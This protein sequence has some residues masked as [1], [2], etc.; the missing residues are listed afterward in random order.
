MVRG[1][2]MRYAA[3]GR[4]EMRRQELARDTTDNGAASMMTLPGL[5]A[6]ALEEFLGS[7]MRRRFDESHAKTLEIAYRGRSIRDPRRSPG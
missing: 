6:D 5:A 1:A 7:F 4:E 3:S 2:E